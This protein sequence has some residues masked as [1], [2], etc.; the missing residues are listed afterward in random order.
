MRN[1]THGLWAEEDSLEEQTASAC[2]SGPGVCVQLEQ[3]VCMRILEVY[4]W[5]GAGESGMR[6]AKLGRPECAA[7]RMKLNEPVNTA[8]RV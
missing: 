4:M 6:Q 8:V 2:A 3:T 5:P 1:L 7:M